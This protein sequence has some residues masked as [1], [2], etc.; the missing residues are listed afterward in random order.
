[1]PSKSR[2]S[3]KS[4]KGEAEH[5]SPNGVELSNRSKGSDLGN[6][7]SEDAPHIPVMLE[8]CLDLLNI[9]PG[10]TYLDA[11]AGAGG[12]LLRIAGD[13]G[14]GSTIF[15]V[16]RDR[17]AIE[18][19]Q[20]LVPGNVRLIHSN[21]SQFRQNLSE[22]GVTTIDGGIL[23][24]LG[25]SSMQLDEAERG[26]SFLRNGPL[27]MRM[28]QSKGQTAEDLLNTASEHELADIIF[29]YG[30]ER[31]SR[32]IARSIVYHRP[33]K[34]T[35]EL[36]DLVG[37]TLRKFQKQKSWKDSAGPSKHPA[38][39]TF[40][41]IRMAVNEELQCLEKFL[42]DAL[43]MLAPGAR[44]VVITFH[45]LEDRMVKQFLRTASA[46]CVCPPRQPVCTCNKTSQLLIITRKPLVAD[47]KE[48]LANVRSRSA[49]LRAAEKLV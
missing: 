39:R 43:A 2:S 38:T 45:S 34:T 30:E 18:R 25:V 42:E 6:G 13:A 7:Q 28:D 20:K 49:K 21:Y 36:S 44:L 48:V 47:E 40:Q 17:Y 23:A 11:T 3:R 29:R 37:N 46:S 32:Q 12:H 22:Q 24:D 35:G 27:D 19:L 10:R 26:F 1:M 9:R 41:A 15:G 16:D 14:K 8:E 5:A 31:F 4:G 33:I